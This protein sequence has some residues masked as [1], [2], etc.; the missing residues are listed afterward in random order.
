M[1]S[2]RSTS[3]GSALWRSTPRS[4][5]TACTSPRGTRRT[6]SAPDRRPS[7]TSAVTASSKSR[8]VPAPR[9]F[10]PGTASSRRTRTSRGSSRQRGS[11][12]SARRPRRSRRW[13]RRSQPA[14]TCVPRGCRSFRGRCR[15]RR[16][17][18][19]SS[20]RLARSAIRSPSRRRPGAVERACAWRGPKT[21]SSVR[22][23]RRAARARRTSPTVPYTSSA[24]SRTRGMSKC[25]SLPTST[26]T[27]FTSESATARFSDVTRSSSRRRR[28]RRST[29]SCGRTSAVSRS[30]LR[31][32]SDTARRERSRAS[33]TPTA[34]T[35]SS[36]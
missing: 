3:S 28:L 36:R 19:T 29:M 31:A 21:R 23:S 8:H 35:T 33:S 12:G 32:L 27:S 20:T 17:S 24:T 22:S 16:L 15:Q 11:F 9:R 18:P 6:C 2:G 34:R 4:I 26:G 14:S 13:G 25:R 7:P 5:G 1:S 10:I 30:T